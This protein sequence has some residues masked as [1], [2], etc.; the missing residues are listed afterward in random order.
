MDFD[1]GSFFKA[2]SDPNR[3]KIMS[4]L[5]RRKEMSVSDICKHFDMK[6]PSISHHLGILKNAKIVESRKEGK[7]VYYRL[8]ACCVSSCCADF[9][10]QFP[11]DGQTGATQAGK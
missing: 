3:V 10:K 11:G 7:E 2:V 6:Q 4:L 5:R 9:M 8:N 1:C